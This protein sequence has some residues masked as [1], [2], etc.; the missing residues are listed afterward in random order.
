MR[1]GLAYAG[2]VRGARLW[3]LDPALDLAIPG[4]LVGGVETGREAVHGLRHGAAGG[5]DHRLAAGEGLDDRKTETFVARRIGAKRTGAIDRGQRAVADV[6]EM[7]QRC[8]RAAH[9]VDLTQY[10]VD[11][12]S[13]PTDENELEPVALRDS[14][15][16]Q[17]AP[18]PDQHAVALARLD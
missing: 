3:V 5:G 4:V 2:L 13:R 11:H 18:Y 7:D 15:R 16:E 6:G 10:V 14:G 8:G 9:L 1:E 12:P 17:P